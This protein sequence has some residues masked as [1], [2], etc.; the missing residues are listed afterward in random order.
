LRLTLH[1]LRLEAATSRLEDIA[2]AQ[3]TGSVTLQ[4]TS[5]ASHRASAAPP[6]APIVP[7]LGSRE[8]V[9]VAPSLGAAP[10]VVPASVSAFDERIIKTK[11][12]NFLNLTRELGY[13][14]LVEQVWR[15][16]LSRR[17]SIEDLLGRDG[18][19]LVCCQSVDRPMRF[20]LQEAERHRI[21]PIT[22]AHGEG[23]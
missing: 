14:P 12:R 1:F 13:G 10:D 5:S 6:A 11:L 22:E 21:G 19:Q 18:I 17:T 8:H 16:V 23:L 15:R 7:P 3:A 4:P 2:A 9:P 20:R